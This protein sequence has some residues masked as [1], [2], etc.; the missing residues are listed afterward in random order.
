M[1]LCGGV[2]TLNLSP[3]AMPELID[4][5]LPALLAAVVVF[6]V[7]SLVHM[8]LPIHKGDYG[9]MPNEEPVLEAMRQ[10]GVGPGHYMVPG[11]T[12]MQEAQTP[13]FQEKLAKGPVGF[14]TLRQ[15]GPFAMGKQLGTWFLFALVVSVCVAYVLSLSVPVGYDA[16]AFRIAA[17]VGFMTYGLSA[18]TESIWK[19][20]SWKITAKF[21]F[22]GLLYGLATGAVFMWMWPA[23][24]DGK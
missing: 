12:S 4:L 24:S 9:V 3:Q 7:S 23:G 1:T 14:M 5:L 18:S 2:Q 21:W 8:V 15:P 16:R 6:F 10:S 20:V 17:T 11:C 19:C 13:E 22:D